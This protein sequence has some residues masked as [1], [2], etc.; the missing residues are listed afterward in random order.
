MLAYEE[1][2]GA[3]G[4]EV[5]FRAPRYE[6]RKLFPHLPP[7]VGVNASLHK[8]HDI[9]LGGIAIVCNQTAEDIP[10][11]GEVV[12]VTLQQSGLTDLRE[13]RARL[14]TE[15]TVFGSKVA[16]KF[17][18][19]FVEFDKLLSR[20]VQAQIAL[21][22]ALVNVE[23][24]Q[25][26]PQEYRVFFA[27][28][29]DCSA[30]IATFSTTI[31]CWRSN[32]SRG[33]DRDGAFEA[34]EA[35]LVQH[36][37]ALWR[38]G[39]E[40]VRPSWEIARCCEATKTFTEV[41]VTPVLRR[42]AIWDRSYGKPLGYPGDFEVMNQVYDWQ[43]RGTNVYEMLIHRL[44]L[45]VAEC[46]KTR[47]EV[48]RATIGRWSRR[49][50]SAGRA[51]SSVSAAGRRAKS[52]FPQQRRLEEQ[53]RRIHADRPGTGGAQLRHRADLSSCA[54]RQGP[55]ARAVPEYV[56]H[57]HPAR[58]RRTSS[59]PPQDLIYS[60]GL[61]DYL[62]D[63]RAQA[64]DPPALR[65]A[66]AG[67]PADHRQHE[68]HAVQQSLADGVHHRLESLLPDRCRNDRVD[69]RFRAGRA[70]GPS[71]RAP[72]ACGCSSSA[73]RELRS[74]EW[75]VAS[76]VMQEFFPTPYSLLPTRGA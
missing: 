23:T 51:R 4:R 8:L 63:R 42:G 12:P 61:L 3:G 53:A 66:R 68:R 14:P 59:L 55:G 22:S 17:V 74:R 13:Q 9:S 49:R 67:R 7:R 24:T 44:G 40:L 54:E 25:L 65:S 34:C 15:D 36:W 43:R 33:F 29:S 35:R 73:S 28:V 76:R 69:R 64:L 16:F 75:R 56:L 57:R 41:V 26:V 27:D 11:V 60:V 46:I 1:L 20:N 38:T 31:P 30:P 50:A 18:N 21:Q 19:G 37:R 52:S 39:N 10:E 47:M 71:S 45:E 5:W 2:K 48:V 72:N 62:A 6:A 58:H 32:S 70:R